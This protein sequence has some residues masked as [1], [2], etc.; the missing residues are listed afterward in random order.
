ML[1]IEFPLCT[2]LVPIKVLGSLMGVEWLEEEVKALAPLTIRRAHLCV[3]SDRFIVQVL[4]WATSE[5]PESVYATKLRG[6]CE[7][8]LRVRCALHVDRDAT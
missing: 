1:K 7:Q 2:P 8:G 3:T 4:Y 6:S 5:P